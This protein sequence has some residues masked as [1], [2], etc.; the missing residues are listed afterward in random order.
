[1]ATPFL[2]YKAII[3]KDA[4]H[5]PL[6]T[7]ERLSTDSIPVSELGGNEIQVL[8]DGLYVGPIRGKALYYV[9]GVTGNDVPTAGD[10]ATPIKTLDYAL[11]LIASLS[12]SIFSGAAVVALQAGQTFD[13]THTF[14]LAGALRITFYGDPKYGDW[15]S[16]PVGT[17]ALYMPADLQ[18]PVINVGFAPSTTQGL[19]GF[20]T[21]N[22]STGRR[23]SLALEGVRFNLPTG[24][25]GTGSGTFVVANQFTNLDIY[26][27]GTIINANDDVSIYGF[28][29]V[30][31]SSNVYLYQ[32]GS[33]FWVG[34][35]PLGLNPTPPATLQQLQRRSSF[36]KMYPD[37]QPTIQTGY[38][39]ALNGSAGSGLLSL[40]W[41]DVGD[42]STAGT[43][44]VLRTWPFL[45]DPALGLAQYF[46]LLRRDQQG[47][48]LNVISGRLF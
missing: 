17:V 27:Q 8:A 22:L 42:G 39:T 3:Y 30:L 29:S 18:R 10:K 13:L 1:M 35:R 25:Y 15:N 26:L 16:S 20:I 31:P 38:D 44:P 24:T 34:G 4:V 45:S 19:A 12:G 46:S 2:Y 40:S 32:F 47:R 36:I 33:Q 23:P 5:Q 6:G 28:L 41:T 7:D 9:N 37:F 43:G 14:N 21:Q 48:P 11:D